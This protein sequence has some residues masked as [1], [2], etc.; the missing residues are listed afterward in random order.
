MSLPPLDPDRVYKLLARTAWEQALRD[1]AWPGSAHD[2]RDGYVH[3]SAAGQVADTLGK[4]FATV[5]DLALVAFDPVALGAALRWERSRGGTL[6]PHLY[7]PLPAAGGDWIAWRP[8]AG[9]DWQ[10]PC[11]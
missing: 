10:A 5:E 11:A 9:G 2:L 3:L 1:G 8:Q 6:F 4:Y 7:A